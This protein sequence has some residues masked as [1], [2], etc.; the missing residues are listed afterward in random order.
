MSTP[1][2]NQLATEKMQSDFTYFLELTELLGKLRK[3]P[4]SSADIK[5]SGV[6][7]LTLK[8]TGINVDFGI[9]PNGGVNAYMIPPS[10]DSNHP[11]YTTRGMRWGVD[12]KDRKKVF[13]KD[14]TA[15][16]W[17]DDSQYMVGGKWSDMPVVLRILKGVMNHTQFTDRMIAALY[18]HELGHVYTYFSL[19]GR[20]TTKNFLTMEAI[21]ELTSQQPIDKR[22]MA[23]EILEKDLDIEI[24]NKERIASAKPSARGEMVESVA[25]VETVA[26]S[27]ATSFGGY[28]S[29][30]VEQIADQFAVYHGAGADLAYALTTIYK[31]FKSP[32]TFSTGGFVV[33]ELIKTMVFI[34]F[35]V[36]IPI[37]G[38]LILLLSIP[39]DKIYDDPEARVEVTRKQLVQA[40]KDTKGQPELHKSILDQIEAIEKLKGTLKDRRSLYTTIYQTITPR[41]RTMY[42]QE[43]FM[44][45]IENMLY[46]DTYLNAARFGALNDEL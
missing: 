33:L 15:T 11:F 29:R 22:I 35:T 17:V 1:L 37:L 9:D 18:L 19:F 46:N 7:E 38:I 5:K 10:L 39:G 43:V 16:A 40:L 12:K 30:N 8:H 36:A 3:T 25:I 34:Y 21:K 28:E 41:G 24:S 42:R 2:A 45:S 27:K 13:G 23:L 4:M 14:R 44:K 31:V 32:E 20:L 6:K 26:G